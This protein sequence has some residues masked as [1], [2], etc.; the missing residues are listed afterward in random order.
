MI[1]YEQNT[2]ESAARA[3]ESLCHKKHGPTSRTSAMQ[4]LGSDEVGG[5]LAFLACSRFAGSGEKGFC[6]EGPGALQL[7]RGAVWSGQSVMLV[8]VVANL[9][10]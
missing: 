9:S 2:R 1:H 6:F 5:W 7:L 10:V 4:G 8:V 3:R